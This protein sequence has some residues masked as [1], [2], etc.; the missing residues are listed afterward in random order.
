M[1]RGG[2]RKGAGRKPILNPEQ[3]IK[4]YIKYKELVASYSKNR[5]LAEIKLREECH[6]LDFAINGDEGL[7]RLRNVFLDNG[8]CALLIAL[9]I[10]ENKRNNISCSR[11]DSGTCYCEHINNAAHELKISSDKRDE[12]GRF[13]KSKAHRG[14]KDEVIK[15]CVKWANEAYDLS[16][17]ESY[18]LDLIKK[19][20]DDIYS[21]YI[22][23][24]L[25]Q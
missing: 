2:K 14:Y 23:F 22:D 12:L 18:V 24:I 13:V 9:D 21:E 6:D 19:N 7:E 10:F 1:G 20:R 3:R 11:C 17:K 15:H 8:E 16:L 25:D 4:L 5:Q